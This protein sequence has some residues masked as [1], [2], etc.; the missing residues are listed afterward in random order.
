[1]PSLLIPLASDLF[2]VV[3]TMGTGASGH[4]PRMVLWAWWFQAQALELDWPGFKSQAYP[5]ASV[6][7]A[8]FLAWRGLDS[9]M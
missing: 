5:S 2:L 4:L 7:Q 6:P 3:A 9:L 8:E 1:M